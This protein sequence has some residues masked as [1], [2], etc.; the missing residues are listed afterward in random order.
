MEKIERKLTEA[1]KKIEALE[2]KVFARFC[3]KL[4]INNIRQYEKGDLRYFLNSQFLIKFEYY[5]ILK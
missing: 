2:N 1:K 3:Q 5:I 4:D